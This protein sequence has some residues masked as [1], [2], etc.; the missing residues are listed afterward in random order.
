VKFLEQINLK[1]NRKFEFLL[2]LTMVIEFWRKEN[3][4]HVVVAAAVGWFAGVCMCDAD[5]LDGWSL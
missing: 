5:H 1:T 2:F 3:G 4:F